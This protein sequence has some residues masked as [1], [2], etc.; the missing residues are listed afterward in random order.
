MSAAEGEKTR[1]TIGFFLLS[2]HISC[3]LAR[4]VIEKEMSHEEFPQEEITAYDYPTKFKS[5]EVPPP[6]GSSSQNEE[7]RVSPS[8][9]Y[10]TGEFS[11]AFLKKTAVATDELYLQ[12]VSI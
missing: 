4:S 12:Q 9:H 6:S 11:S 8:D 3:G 2:L 5:F 1:R 10:P 7:P